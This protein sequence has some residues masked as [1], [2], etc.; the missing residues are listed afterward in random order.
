MQSIIN[1]FSVAA[2]M[3]DYIADLSLSDLA[4]LTIS[5][6]A[7]C[8]RSYAS[9]LGIDG[10]PSEYTAK[11]FLG[12]LRARGLSSR[13]LSI[14]YH[15]IRPFLALQGVIL[16][17]KFKRASRLPGYTSAAQ[18]AAVIRAVQ[19]RSDNWQ[20]LSHRDIAI[21]YTLAYTGVRRA[22]LLSLTTRNI[23][24]NARTIRVIGK[25]DQERIIPMC[26]H[27]YNVLLPYCKS[28][29]N[30]TRL[31]PI[32][33]RRLCALIAR[34]AE[35]AAVPHLHPHNFRHFFATQLV[36]S[37]VPLHA[38]QKLLGHRDISTTA[39]YLDL[40][41]A[42]LQRAVDKLPNFNQPRSML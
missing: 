15:A 11:S 39:M 3:A 40:V 30:S 37:G 10:A 6:Y 13:S 8:L 33:A 28:I 2:Q 20:Q 22:E 41:P 27:L 38:I 32:A 9:Y 26:D 29:P 16:K 14:Y 12:Q 17:L 42:H 7:A 34:Y 24:L 1:Q 23:D 21:I 25:G 18:V 35:V 31:F 36:E 5:R 19:S 4:P